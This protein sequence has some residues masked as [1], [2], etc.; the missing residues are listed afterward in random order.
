MDQ[1]KPT[2]PLTKNHGSIARF[3]EAFASFD[4]IKDAVNQ[5]F[6]GIFAV[7]KQFDELLRPNQNLIQEIAD[8]SQRATEAMRP[9]LRMVDEHRSAFDRIAE[10]ASV[11]ADLVDKLLP[12]AKQITDL[13]Q[14][15]ETQSF[16]PSYDDVLFVPHRR[17][18][19]VEKLADD[20]AA[21]VLEQLSKREQPAGEKRTLKVTPF[22]EDLTW[23]KVTIKFIDGH[24]V[25][26]FYD[27][28]KVRTSYA[29][30]GFRDNRKM[31]PN[32]QWFLLQ[33]LAA[34]GGMLAWGDSGATPTAKK[35]KQLLSGTL[36]K[37]FGITDDPFRPYREV[38]GYEIKLELIPDVTLASRLRRR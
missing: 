14:Q 6:G 34:N 4:A 26:I 30:M 32:R 11:R 29:E 12:Y 3:P 35:M 28:Q 17:E 36:K 8:V 10:I 7:Q 22:P 9:V 25:E 21:R 15:W 31:M 24:D 16:V 23:E 1:A 33:T 13:R 18:I 5:S 19:D 37:Y 38:R 2:V 27:D 20:V